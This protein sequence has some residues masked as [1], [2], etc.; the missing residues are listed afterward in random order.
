MIRLGPDGAGTSLIGADMLFF[1]AGYKP[2][3]ADMLSFRAG[4]KSFGADMLFSSGYEDD[5]Q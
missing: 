2:F 1:R 3:G 5:V 4:Y